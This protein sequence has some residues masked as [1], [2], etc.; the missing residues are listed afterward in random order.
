MG[1]NPVIVHEIPVAILRFS[2][3][4]VFKARELE[5]VVMPMPEPASEGC[6]FIEGPTQKMGEFLRWSKYTSNCFRL[7]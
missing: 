4:Y 6:E 1:P 2:L 7:P 3:K 5:D